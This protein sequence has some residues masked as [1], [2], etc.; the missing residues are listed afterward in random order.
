MNATQCKA[1]GTFQSCQL[2]PWALE[3]ANQYF[4]SGDCQQRTSSSSLPNSFG[5][6]FDCLVYTIPFTNLLDFVLSSI[7]PMYAQQY[8]SWSTLRS[9][10]YRHGY[11]KQQQV[12]SR[13]DICVNM[14]S[15]HVTA[16]VTHPINKYN[17][18]SQE[19]PQPFLEQQELSRTF[20]IVL[21]RKASS[22]P[23]F[24]DFPKGY[25]FRNTPCQRPCDGLGSTPL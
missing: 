3:W 1:I 22:C 5:S 9:I 13:G 2:L 7:P 14:C 21:Q 16:T 25:M 23:S 4:S 18:P 17:K 12:V 8:P 6:C 20:H 10:I 11:N 24:D 19:H 15:I